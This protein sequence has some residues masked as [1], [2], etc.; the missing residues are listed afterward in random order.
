[1]KKFLFTLL[2]FAAMCFANYSAKAQAGVFDPSDADQVFT[3]SNKPAAPAYGKVAKWGHTKTY[4]WGTYANGYK[5]YYYNGMAFRLKFPKSYTGTA[6]GKIYPVYVFLHGLGELGTIYDNELQLLHGGQLHAQAVDNGSFDGFLI[7]PQSTSGWLQPYTPLL[8]N[9]VDSLIKYNKADADRVIFEGLSGGGQACWDLMQSSTYMQKTAALVTISAAK[10]DDIPYMSNGIT[11]PIW[12]T[13]GGLDNDPSPDLAQTVI[14]SFT[15]KGGYIIHGFYP[16][17]AHSTWDPLWAEA[18]YYPFLNAAHKANPLVYFQRT[19]FCASDP[20]N[21]KL[22]IQAGFNAYQ[23]RKDSVVINSATS[24]TLQVTAYGKYQA[25][26]RRTATGAWSAWSPIPVI[27]SQKTATVTPPIQVSGLAS[28]VLPAPDGS[29]TVPITVPNTYASYEWHKVDNGDVVVG[30]SAIY[31]AAVGQYKVRVTEQYGCSS[32]FSPVYSVISASGAN[33]PDKATNLTALALSSTSVELDWSNNPNPAYNETAFEVYRSTTS[34]SNY[35]MVAITGADVLT[36]LETGL[37]PNT[38]YYYIVRAINNNGASA[39]SNEIS[40]TTKSDVTA[41]TAPTNL[42]V[43]GT[44]RSTVSLSWGESSD[45]VG[46]YKYDIY[47]NGTK[48]YSTSNTTFTVANLTALQTYAFTVKAR[49][50]TGNLSPASNQ[51][52]AP[53]ALSGLTYEYYQGAWTSLPDFNALLPFSTGT[54]ANVTLAPATQSTNFGFLWQGFIKIPAAGTYTFETN[55]DDGSKLYIGQYSYSATPVVNNDGAHSA[56]SKTGTITLS[57]GIYPIAIAYFN[58]TGGGSIQVYW[59][60]SSIARQ[61]IPDNAF[62]DAVTPGAAPAK[63]SAITITPTAYNSIN[64]GWT[65]NS[66]NETGFEVSR[67]TSR[68]GIYIPIGTTAANATSFV[69]SVGLSPVTQYWYKIRAI[70]NNGASDYVSNLKAAWLF[71]NDL[72]DATN[73]GYTLTGSGSPTYSTDK[74]E[75]ANAVSL[76]GS[77]QYANI[78]NGTTFPSDSYTTRT[79]SV[80]IKPTAATIAA[81]NKIV[82]ELGGADNGLALRFNSG[83]LQAGIAGNSNRYTAVVNTVATNANWVSNGWNHVV[84]VYNVNSLQLYLNGVLKATTSLGISS[85]GASTVGSR[86]GATNGANAFNSSTSSTNY[87]GLIDDLEIIGEALN[88]ADITALKNGTYTAGTTLALPAVPT[89]PS[90]LN[91]QAVS[92]TKINLSFT[93]NSNNETG[94][95]IYRSVVNA[96]SFKLAATLNAGVTSYADS[97][98]FANTNYYYKVRAIGVGGASAFTANAGTVTLNNRPVITDINSFAVRYGTSTTINISAADADADPITFTTVSVPSFATFTPGANGTATLQINPATA[99]ANGTYAISIIANDNHSGAD[100]TTFTLTVNANYVPAPSAVANQTVAEGSALTVPVSATDVDGNAS[101]VWSLTSAPAFA[102]IGAT[103]NGAATISFNPNYATAGTYAITAT[104]TD[105][106]GGVATTTFTV[107]VTDVAP[108]SEK[109]YTDMR[110][111]TPN[112]PA[113]WNNISGVTTTGLKNSL[114]QT[115]TVGLQFLGT[116]WNAGNASN[117]TGNNSGVYPDAAIADYFW[118]GAYG[119]PETITFNVTGLTPASKYNLT[120][121]SGS[122]WQGAG[123]N[124]TT[125]FTINGV[126]KSI[127]TNYNLQTTATFSSQSPDASGT[128]AVTM[129]KDVNTPYGMVNTIVIEKQ[130]DDFTAPA[131]PTNLTAQVLSS[132]N[133]QLRWKDVAYNENNYLVSRATDANGPYTVLN[134]G[135]ANA[136]DTTYTDATVQGNATYYY[137][138]EATNQYGSSGL[139][140]AVSATTI[141]KAPVLPALADVQLKGGASTVLNITA[142]D[143]ASNTLV[144]SV[145]GLPSFATYQALGNGTGK[146]T[147]TPSVDDLG[148]YKNVVVKVTDNFGASVAD[149]FNVNVIDSSL[150]TVY[151]KF[152]AQNAKPQAKPWNNYLSYPFANNPLSNLTDDANNNTGFSIKLNNAWVNNLSFGMITGD[153]SGIAPDNVLLGNIEVDDNTPRVV[154]IDGL[155]PAKKYDVGFVSSL[156]AGDDATATYASGGKTITFNGMYNSN[157]M[158]YLNGLTP[159]ASGAI[160]ITCTKAA[161]A[162]YMTLNGMQ[163]HEYNASTTPVRPFNLF[164]ESI[165][166]SS[167]VK[168]TWSDRSDSESGFQVYRATAPAGPY[169]LVTTT[170]QNATTYTVTGLA[171]NTRYYFKVRAMN[172]AIASNYSNIATKIL[173]NKTVLINLNFNAAQNQAAPWN[174]TNGPSTEGATF[175]NLLD[176]TG[177]N[178]GVEMIITKELNGAGFAGSTSTTGV[179]PA[180]VMTSNYWTDAGQTSEVKFDNLDVRKKYRIGI[181]GSA[182]NYGYFFGNYSCNGKKVQLNSYNNSTK[183]VY[184]DNL[185]PSADG[186]LYVDINTEAGYPYTFTSAFMIESYDDA[187]TFVPVVLNRAAVPVAD[188]NAAI[189]RATVDANVYPTLFTNKLTVELNDATAGKAAISL[190][191]INGRLVYQ[192]TIVKGTGKQV[193]DIILPNASA[194]RI[195]NY[196]INVK[197]ENKL[198]KSLVLMKVN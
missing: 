32:N 189:E 105:G 62:S 110:Y 157:A 128:I 124:G 176:N 121:Y 86:V 40:V 14:D 106:A 68:L 20:I 183:I 173:S 120:F 76:N 15:S 31:N 118:F 193:S 66:N 6:D 43:T 137:K 73:N 57:A 44:T 166:D 95:E 177:L 131:L 75:G 156:D 154:E 69:D 144:T 87:G 42:T 63:P 41:P 147:F 84:V 140:A 58:A 158:P 39:V 162:R 196:I 89:A 33:A 181:F 38:K 148:G 3:A 60:S 172:G 30:T 190:F 195:G 98:L 194:L 117:S 82:Y 167:K 197:L 125:I 184:L 165:L 141:N 27:I 24:N 168:L 55:S 18:S 7:Y 109:I 111:T 17:S 149:T 85:V 138:L 152:D 129:S 187:S 10:K 151:I 133:V 153:N 92:S 100:T 116:P 142:T 123:P 186:E 26:F 54:T 150:R 48:V 9:I 169:T 53:A 70:N 180:N 143:D 12:E 112:A 135:A 25:R 145:T 49:D 51:V 80:W 103:T 16:N 114:G 56:G 50:L 23:W 102:S 104:V 79:V 93:D 175:S 65:D 97:N 4:T 8:Y 90:A 139:T 47:V 178:S 83:A 28:N 161:S 36:D 134:A 37:T 113:P 29:T 130:F 74:V 11:L 52:S 136:N 96:T 191:D 46:V 64:V 188:V 101:L 198:S 146:I 35:K 179:L 22:G 159:T 163:I 2:A 21:V 78:N 61:L 72:T 107:T 59:K 182:I 1:M 71:N 155:N 132:G 13:N 5:S 174:N 81:A 122:T 108:P 127:Y 19:Q 94:F 88:T 160:L 115:T 77:S 34:G 192:G 119:A 171:S 185:T 45:D 170:G 164:A 126:S 99:S 67:S 91:A